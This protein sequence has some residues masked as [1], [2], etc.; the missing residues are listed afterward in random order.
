MSR[1]RQA[2]LDNIDARLAR[3]AARQHGRVSIRQL[4]ALGLTRQAVAQ[5]VAAG[6]LHPEHRGVYLVGHVVTTDDGRAMAAVMACGQGALLADVSAARMWGLVR[7]SP[8]PPFHVASRTGRG[9]GVSGVLAHRARHEPL[10]ATRL[11][12]VPVVTP[13]RAL[14]E[15]ALHLSP[16]ELQ[17]AVDRAA[18]RGLQREL[19]QIAQR[20]RGHHGLGA[21]TAALAR[22]FPDGDRT[23]S[24]LEL[25]AM[26]LVVDHGLLKPLVAVEIGG[27]EVDLF[28]PGQG[29]VV[30]LDGFAFHGD[31]A[32]FEEDRRK[33]ADLQALG[34]TVMRFTWL[35]AD[36]RPAWMVS[37]IAA[38]LGR[39][40]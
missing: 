26:R 15:V 32:S 12:H 34:L 35:Q 30:E 28:W 8:G 38:R 2:E 24:D 3:L 29:L 20:S 39:A 18:A 6:R 9:R 23:R 31:R 10:D 13:A 33:T 14:L 11:R 4:L 22:A 25:L 7:G 1:S 40:A 37:R 27:I 5:R 16:P 17:G 19:E 36:E 21:L